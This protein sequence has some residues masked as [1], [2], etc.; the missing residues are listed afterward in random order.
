MRPR[1]ENGT[2][3]GIRARRCVIGGFGSI[4]TDEPRYLSYLRGDV[5]AT[6]FLFEQ[7]TYQDV[8]PDELQNNLVDK[9]LPVIVLDAE[10][11]RENSMG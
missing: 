3:G 10:R 6:Q 5:R 8:Y 2:P 11:D 9:A 4:P 1:R 7:L